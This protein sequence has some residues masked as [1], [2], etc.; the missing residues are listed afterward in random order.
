MASSARS[1]AGSLP[2]KWSITKET[3]ATSI[4]VSR[5]IVLEP[6]D[7]KRPR[8][9]HA[10][11]MEIGGAEYRPGQPPR[12]L[13]RRP[14]K[15]LWRAHARQNARGPR[16]AGDGAP[17]LIYGNEHAVQPTGARRR[18]GRRSLRSCRSWQRD[19]RGGR[20]PRSR[21][22]TPSTRRGRTLPPL[23][24]LM[25]RYEAPHAP[26]GSGSAAS[27]SSSRSDASRPGCSGD[28][29][30][31]GRAAESSRSQ[32]YHSKSHSTFA[33]RKFQRSRNFI[34]NA[35]CQNAE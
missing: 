25:K 2:N 9:E 27:S 19:S 22:A 29:G 30:R 20:R 6:V 10:R 18:G 23:P 26:A 17:D 16:R 15:P 13:A 21:R 7:L 24:T 35:S 12:R 3:N 5:L 31:E 8:Q 33:S 1:S 28:P 11:R 32:S 34:A 14:T 4:R